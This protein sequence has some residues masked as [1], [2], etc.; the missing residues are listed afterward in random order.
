MGRTLNITVAD[1][2]ATYRSRDGYIVCGNSDYVIQFAFDSDW[3][4]HTEKT[5]RFVLNGQFVDVDFTGTECSVPIITN[6]SQVEVGV[7]AGDL[8][9]TTP[10]IIECKKSILCEDAEASVENDKYW[11]NEAKEAANRAEEAAARGVEDSIVHDIGLSKTKAISQ[12]GFTNKTNEI[13]DTISDNE[14]RI[15]ELLYPFGHIIPKTEIGTL[16]CVNQATEDDTITIKTSEPTIYQTNS[17]LF[18]ANKAIEV[19]HTYTYSG[20]SIYFKNGHFMLNGTATQDTTIYLSNY[21]DKVRCKAGSYYV[22]L[23]NTLPEGVRCQFAPYFINETTGEL[24]T[25]GQTFSY[26]HE[27]GKYKEKKIFHRDFYFQARLMIPKDTKFYMFEIK[28]QLSISEEW[29][30]PSRVTHSIKNSGAISYPNKEIFLFADSYDKIEVSYHWKMY[31]MKETLEILR[32]TLEYF[33]K[34]YPSF[35]LHNAHIE[36]INNST[37]AYRF[38]QFVADFTY[39][40]PSDEPITPTLADF[41]KFVRNYQAGGLQCVGVGVYAGNEYQGY[42]IS[43]DENNLYFRSGTN[44]LA[45][46]ANDTNWD[47][48]LSTDKCVRLT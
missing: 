16:V 13:L 17:N 34:K 8:C 46:P 21:L 30:T 31:S 10:A 40:W 29:K 33:D 19:D 9:T 23:N 36:A 43:A 41:H 32:D 45:I 7:Y 15:S 5:A 39:Y 11:A 47:L 37:D 26:Y 1:K 22:S 6:V 24:S 28:P 3:D 4:A 20:V 48:S 25:E 38:E 35:F 42:W 27:N 2:V 18:F 12:Y 14:E 44:Q